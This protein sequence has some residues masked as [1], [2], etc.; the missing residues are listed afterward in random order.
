[1]V[2]LPV[3]ISSL[4]RGVVLLLQSAVRGD[5]LIGADAMAGA[6]QDAGWVR[7]EGSGSWFC[8]A[9]PAWTV[10]S[11][12]HPPHVS[13]FPQGDYEALVLLAAA[14][15]T[16]LESGQVG[17]LLAGEP[18][19]GWSIW[20]G[21]DVVVSLIVGPEHRVGDNVIPAL[22]QLALDRPD[23]PRWG[24][25]LDPA[26]ARRLAEEGSP[27]A[28]WYLAGESH[29]PDDVVD[30]LARDDD[31]TVVAALAANEGQRRLGL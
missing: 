7:Q 25:R 6:L 3:Q 11:S 30:L 10:E 20:S 28:R 16:L 23:T 14:V 24:P 2:V 19:L 31:A 15:R 5:Q 22:L 17:A 4:P 21:T 13:I 27:V 12:A 29:L 9:E 8:S 18:D 1:M 26:R